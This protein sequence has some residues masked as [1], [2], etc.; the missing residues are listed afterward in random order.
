[1]LVRALFVFLLFP[2]LSNLKGIPFANLLS[3]LTDGAGCFLNIGSKISGCDGAPV[4]PLL[5]IATN[6]SFNISL[7]HLVNISSTIVSSL[8]VMLSIQ[9]YFSLSSLKASLAM[10]PISW[11]MFWVL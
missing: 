1:M 3:Y 2:F 6:L 10:S 4:L 11:D 9:F 7:L 5:Y 8:A